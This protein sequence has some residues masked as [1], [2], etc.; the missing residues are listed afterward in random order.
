MS[1]FHAIVRDLEGNVKLRGLDSLKA[2]VPPDEDPDAYLRQALPEMVGRAAE[3]TAQVWWQLW[4]GE[5]LLASSANAPAFKPALGGDADVLRTRNTLWAH[6]I[7][8]QL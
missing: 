2:N 6:T 8:E 3:R 4:E 5:E 7:P 1:K